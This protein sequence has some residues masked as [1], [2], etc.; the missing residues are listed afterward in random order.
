MK[1]LIATSL[2]L[3]ICFAGLLALIAFSQRRS[4]PD[5]I[6]TIVYA[7]SYPNPDPQGYQNKL[8]INWVRPANLLLGEQ[9]DTLL[10]TER[11]FP[12]RLIDDLD[13][14]PVDQALM[15]S[16]EYLYH[17]D[18][19]SNA[20]RQVS[21]DSHLVL[22]LAWSPDGQ[23]F[24]FTDVHGRGRGLFIANA[25]GS[26]LS[27]LTYNSTFAG[28][29]AWSPDSD[30]IA[31]NVILSMGG[32]Q[33][34][35]IV[36]LDLGA[37]TGMFRTIYRVENNLGQLS[38]SPDG[39]RIAFQMWQHGRFDIYTL[40][41][42]GSNLTRLTEDHQQNVDPRWSPDGSLI[43]YSSL[44]A[45]EHYQLY[46]MNADGSDAHLVFA[47]PPGQDAYNLCWLP[48]QIQIQKENS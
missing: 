37:G 13:C 31:L 38:W 15:V 40:E 10:D 28:A 41:T 6:G 1:R 20:L 14:S 7:L 26:N 9:F 44:D 16:A 24:A 29:L 8:D 25:D 22:A 21:A 45:S 36:I 46:V 34:Y 12:K 32:P 5:E 2:I 42:D 23:R 43:S 47:V 39:K 11:A 4:F 33:Q 3:S 17:L 19:R 35:G 18:I 27:A 48:A 30:E